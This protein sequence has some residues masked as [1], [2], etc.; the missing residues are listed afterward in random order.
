[1]GLKLV[2]AQQSRNPDRRE[3]RL[4]LLEREVDIHI[5]GEYGSAVEALQN[6][7]LNYRLLKAGEAVMI[8]NLD[9][10]TVMD[11]MRELAK[12]GVMVGF[13]GGGGTPLASALDAAA[14]L[15]DA[16]TREHETLSRC[17]GLVRAQLE[18]QAMVVPTPRPL[19]DLSK[20]YA[21]NTSQ[22]RAIAKSMNLQPQ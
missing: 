15:V 11:A 17:Y 4:R 22:M 2:T 7:I 6:L 1:M 19:G 14:E 5:Q 9:Y 16:L 8:C 18:A 21:D 13:C 3:S 10:G 20:L 12:A